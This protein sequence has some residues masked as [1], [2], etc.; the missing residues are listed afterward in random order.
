MGTRCVENRL[1]I[2]NRLWKKWKNVRSPRGGF[3]F[4]SHCT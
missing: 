3:F 2:L 1:Q 4:D